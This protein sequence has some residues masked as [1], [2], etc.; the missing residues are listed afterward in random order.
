MELKS[1]ID[2]EVSK[3]TIINAIDANQQ[4]IS[5]GYIDADAHQYNHYNPTIRR[6]QARVPYRVMTGCITGRRSIRLDDGKMGVAFTLRTPTHHVDRVIEHIVATGTEMVAIMRQPKHAPISLVIAHDYDGNR[7]VV[8]RLA[9]TDDLRHDRSGL[10]VIRPTT[11]GLGDYAERAKQ[12]QRLFVIERLHTDNIA[13]ARDA[14]GNRIH[15]H[16]GLLIRPAH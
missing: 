11:D 1:H 10:W 9:T 5:R 7:D 4:Y 14:K 8:L 2:H 16:R 3:N 12:Q 15:L 13:T 6:R